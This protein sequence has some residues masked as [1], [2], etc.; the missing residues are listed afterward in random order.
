[1]DER[2]EY[3]IRLFIKKCI[4]LN[5]YDEQ[6]KFF[7]EWCNG[8]YSVSED[9]LKE[10]KKKY[11][12]DDCIDRLIPVIDKYFTIE[13]LK[14]SIKFFSTDAGKKLIDY[15][16]LQNIGKVS[17]DMGEDIEQDFTIGHKKQE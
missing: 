16:F 10:L 2:K 8:T 3:W 5:S 13:D 1:M 4:F 14:E 17:K 7:I 6:I 15:S 12:I 9:L 11:T